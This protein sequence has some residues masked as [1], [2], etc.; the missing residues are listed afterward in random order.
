MLNSLKLVL[1]LLCI[2]EFSVV[3]AQSEQEMQILLN[4]A[5]SE[6]ADSK[7]RHKKEGK[8][9]SSVKL[10]KAKQQEISSID[11]IEPEDEKQKGS[12]KKFK[13]KGE[14]L[15][16]SGADYAAINSFEE[17]LQRTT[18]KKKLAQLN[19]LAGE[20]ALAVRDYQLAENFF[21]AC[22]D[23]EAKKKKFRLVYF[24]LANALKY[25]EK[26]EEAKN[27]YG[28]FLQAIEGNQSFDLE[29]SIARIGAKGCTYAL[30]LKVPEPKYKLKHLGEE[31]NGPYADFGP[32]TRNK[33][34]F[35]AKI[36]SAEAGEQSAIAKIYSSAIYEDHFSIAQIFSS[37]INSGSEFVCNPSFTRDG[38]SIYFTKCE[39]DGSNQSQ[40]A[41]YTS[42]LVQGVWQE[43]VLVGGGVNLTGTS[44]SHPH[45]VVDENGETRLYFS[46]DRATGRGGKDIWYTVLAENGSFGRIKNMGAPINTRFDEISPFYHTSSQTF[47]YS[48]NGEVGLGGFDVFASQKEEGEWL[49]PFNLETP[50]NSSVDDYDFILD[51]SGERGF[52][53][54]NR[55]GT[56]SLTGPTCCDDIFEIRS[57]QIEL[58]LSSLVYVEDNNGRE[59]LS[60]GLLVLETIDSGL[61]DTLSF[62]GKPA[63]IRLE[64]ENAYLLT[65]NS[66]RYKS[67]EIQFSTHEILRS[68]TLYYDLFLIEEKQKEA[69]DFLGII[70]YEYAESKLTKEAPATLKSIITFLEKNPDTNVEVSAH[71]DDKGP[72]AFNLKLSKERCQAAVN[73][74][75]FSGIDESRI[76]SNWYGETK[77]AAPN[78][79]ADGSDNP[80]GRALNRRTEFHITSIED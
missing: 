56:I 25:Q 16:L 17:A 24:Q 53:V 51:N 73:F 63:V 7:K 31:V 77:P 40:C 27:W 21:Q 55:V 14:A 48:T 35:F 5:E 69:K 29:K 76:I 38:K 34:L 61:K 44:S 79:N 10:N 80:E 11:E 43:A 22:L 72:A 28:N 66:M 47:Y 20:S 13:K 65:A 64:P 8:D 70:Y 57:T 60:E 59:L 67:K 45:I 36:L 32:E 46:S 54:S 6:A 49:E 26:Y 74:L 9:K 23:Q 12:A 3:S 68:D 37:G 30:E 4:I 19:M 2:I 75:K 33:E 62:K 58:Y 50:V 15:S 52:L 18:K 1:C 41:I 71:T 78:T 42:N 39:I